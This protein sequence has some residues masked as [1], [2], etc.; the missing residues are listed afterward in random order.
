MKDNSNN[1]KVLCTLCD[2]N[3]LIERELNLKKESDNF[4]RLKELKNSFILNMSHE[5]KTPLNAI[6]GFS[7]LIIESQSNEEKNELLKYIR[8]NNEKLLSLIS[9]I[10]DMLNIETGEMICTFSEINIKEL[11]TEIYNEWHAHTQP[12]VKFNLLAELKYSTLI[13]F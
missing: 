5:I 3:H 9:D 10:V 7:E 2:I 13:R 8:E 12:D 11:V 6:V 4:I 1:T